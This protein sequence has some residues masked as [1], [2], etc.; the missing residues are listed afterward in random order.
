MFSSISGESTNL[1]LPSME[2]LVQFERGSV[3]AWS[4]LD[5]YTAQIEV[6][7][8]YA[9]FFRKKAWN[10]Y[11]VL[12][13]REAF[14]KDHP[15]LVKRVLAVYEKA[16]L[17]TLA[18]PSEARQILANAAHLPDAVAKKVWERQDFTNSVLGPEQR[19]TIGASGETLKKSQL[20][21][22]EVNIDQVVND[23]ID[24][25]FLPSQVANK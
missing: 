5:P 10:S 20:I 6:E 22:A 13:V 7:E 15:D 19:A 17:W 11:G 24:P 9:I 3:E 12:N 18:N 23:L 21:D 4:G 1:Y 16:R 8:G 2:F 25:E 14:A